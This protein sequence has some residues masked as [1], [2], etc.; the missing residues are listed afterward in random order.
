[1][2]IR[3]AGIM[4]CALYSATLAMSGVK[5]CQVEKKEQISGG[6]IMQGRITDH[7]I[8][9]NCE[10]GLCYAGGPDLGGEI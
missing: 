10:R 9:L 2:L 1:M 3:G 6:V 5:R 4:P 8:E 7:R